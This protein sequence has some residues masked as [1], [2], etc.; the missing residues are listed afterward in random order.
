MIW[1]GKTQGDIF[2]YTQRACGYLLHLVPWHA[3]TRQALLL[4]STNVLKMHVIS[5]PFQTWTK[6]NCTHI[7]LHLF[8]IN[9]AMLSK[10]FLFYF[11]THQFRNV[12]HKIVLTWNQKKKIVIFFLYPKMDI[13]FKLFLVKYIL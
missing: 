5:F 12:L 1:I 2:T 4:Q 9:P 7:F 11:F 3:G 6:L 13:D 10:P 8:V